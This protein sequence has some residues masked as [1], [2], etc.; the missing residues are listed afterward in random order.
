MRFSKAHKTSEH[1]MHSATHEWVHQDAIDRLLQL[2]A[3]E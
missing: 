2:A 3:G 1:P